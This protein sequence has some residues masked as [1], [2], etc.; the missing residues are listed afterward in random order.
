MNGRPRPA[1]SFR[2]VGLIALAV[3][4][5]SA[6]AAFLP[7][8]WTFAAGPET[9]IVTALK[10]AEREDVRLSV[11]GA[12]AELVARKVRFDRMQIHLQPDGRAVV[13]AT[14]DF[15]GRFGQVEVSSL[16]LERVPFRPSGFSWE[17][18]G[19]LF[20]R[21]AAVVTAL[22][23][24]RAAIERG[25]RDSLAQL[26][27]AMDGGADAE[28]ESVL[29]VRDRRYRVDAWYLRSEREEVLVTEEY[30]LTGFTKDRP[31]DEKGSRRLRLVPSGAQFIFSEGLM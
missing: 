4:G 6:I 25:D 29:A 12:E 3:L 19:E 18:E 24:R 7:R 16:G 8:L 15:E 13:N 20:P 9:E 2:A 27:E 14:L 22:E 1:F 10:R 11:P 31:V 28:L 5:V 26:V 17:P 30:R 21:L 23:K